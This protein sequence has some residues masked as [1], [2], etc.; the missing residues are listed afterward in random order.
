SP[1]SVFFRAAGH[2]RL[3][4]LFLRPPVLARG[5]GKFNAVHWRRDLRDFV[6][7][8][9]GAA[10]SEAH[11]TKVFDD[12]VGWSME[13]DPDTLVRTWRAENA[14]PFTRRDQLALA[15]RVRCPVLVISGMKDK[16]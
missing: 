3:G 5:W 11:T 16:I 14:A 12:A 4:A 8:F 6:E 9:I 10:T 7:W 15:R 2:P 1:I 13:T